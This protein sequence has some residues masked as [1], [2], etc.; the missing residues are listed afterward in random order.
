MGLT[1]P[2]GSQVPP[3]N[4]GI[5]DLAWRGVSF[6]GLDKSTF[7]VRFNSAYGLV[8]L[9]L[10]LLPLAQHLLLEVGHRLQEVLALHV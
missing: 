9:Q 2:A 10:S 3:S 7:V 6:R 8:P 1:S 4:R 5:E